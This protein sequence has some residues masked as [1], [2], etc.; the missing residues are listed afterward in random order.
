[1]DVYG[2]ILPCHNDFIIRTKKFMK[3]HV[4][5]PIDI[6]VI[7]VQFASSLTLQWNN[8]KE[9]ITH[10]L[11]SLK[12]PNASNECVHSKGTIHFSLTC[13]RYFDYYDLL[14]DGTWRRRSPH[15]WIYRPERKGMC[16]DSSCSAF[17]PKC[18]YYKIPNLPKDA[19]ISYF[20]D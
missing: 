10:G 3:P 8:D 14:S 12:L 9:I 11:E 16:G 1:M 13:E 19:Y 5:L 17:L 7:I 20:D 6:L 4:N 15:G 18:R 2:L